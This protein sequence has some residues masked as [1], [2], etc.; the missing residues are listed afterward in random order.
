MN[1][2]I[3]LSRLIR[4]IGIIMLPMNNEIK[5]PQMPHQQKHNDDGINQ[6]GLITNE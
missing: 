3:N 5:S 1:D 6:H 2:A 4:Y